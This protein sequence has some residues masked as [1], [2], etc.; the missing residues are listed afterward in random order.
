[1]S[2]IN[3]VSLGNNCHPKM[4]LRRIK[5]PIEES[6]P[7]DFVIT[8][9][10]N[11][12]QCLTDLYINNKYNTE[13]TQIIKLLGNDKKEISVSEKT[14]L[15]VHSFFEHDLVS[16]P[17]IFPAHVKHLTDESLKN[18]CSTFDKR[19]SRL[20]AYMND[21]NSSMAFIRVEY[22]SQRICMRDTLLEL[23]CILN[24]FSCLRKYLIYIN[25]YI[26]DTLCYIK[27]GTFNMDYHIPILFCKCKLEDNYF[28]T[29]KN[30]LASIL[31]DFKSL[32]N[33]EIQ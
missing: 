28:E 29:N 19:C 12:I 2:S 9:M 18:V 25:P 15:H 17:D 3:F 22:E 8:K 16:I 23:T 11:I 27:T 32:T 21:P 24:K 7:F 5:I 20:L 31:D 30:Q 1:M 10:K 14:A 33:I 13:F 4:F 26:D 6:L